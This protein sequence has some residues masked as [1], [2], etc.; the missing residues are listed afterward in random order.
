MQAH[1]RI[2]SAL[3][4]IVN[5]TQLSSMLNTSRSNDALMELLSSYIKSHSLRCFTSRFLR[6]LL[7]V[8]VSTQVVPLSL[9][10]A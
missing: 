10:D 4:P 5:P 9:R 8:M 3:Q 2:H 1:R 7:L 6:H